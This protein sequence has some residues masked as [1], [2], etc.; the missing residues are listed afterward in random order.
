[1]WGKDLEKML[2]DVPDCEGLKYLPKAQLDH[3]QI[4][5]LGYPEQ[6]LLIREE[7]I[8]A[9]NHLTSKSLCEGGGM[10][11]TGQPGIGMESFPVMIT[12]LTSA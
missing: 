1:M 8:F 4:G 3:L 11:V 10:V 2:L 7:Y 6:V 12:L 5:F 9:M